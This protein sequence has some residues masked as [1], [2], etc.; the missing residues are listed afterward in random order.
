MNTLTISWLILPFWV[1]F[2]SYLVP[3]LDRYL[4]LGVTLASI[5]Y[6]SQWLLSTDALTLELLDNFGVT[7]VVDSLSGYFI[8][9]NALVTL[10][11]ILYSWQSSK[12]A[13]FFTQTIILHSSVNVV[14]CCADLISLYVSLEVI[15]IA[16]FLLISYARTDR[17]IWVG[18]R[19]LLISNTVMLFYLIGAIQVYQTQNSFAF[20]GL[21]GAPP[22]AIALIS[23]GLLTK[24]GIFVSGLWLPLTHA[25]ADTPVSALLSGVVVK[26]GIFPLVRLALMVDDLN[27]ILQILSVGTAVLGVSYAIFETDIKRMMALSTISQVGFVLGAPTGAGFYALT[28][29]LAKASLFL[30]TGRLPSRNLEELKQTPL[31]LSTWVVLALAGSSIAGFP[32]LGGFAA[33]TLTLK[34][35]TPWQNLVFTVGAVGTAIVIAKLVFL[36]FTTQAQSQ[37]IKPGYGIAMGVLLGGLLLVNGLHTEAYTLADMGKALITIAIGW[38]AYKLVGQPAKFQ[39]PRPLESLDHLIGGMS[40]MLILLFWLVLA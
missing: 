2:V 37:S 39:L 34:E 31:P 32:L 25:E 27:P 14:F 5:A 13:F 12:S 21:A 40:L 38:L 9:T 17:S 4:A 7:L 35:T 24:G 23:L 26:T 15:S 28:H 10:A 1:G 11:V 36:P 20:T 3:K 29:G 33:K 18:L 8:I 30:T 19:Y 6:S 22:E 16:A